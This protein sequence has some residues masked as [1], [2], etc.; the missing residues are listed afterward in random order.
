MRKRGLRLLFALAGA[1]VGASVS[2]QDSCRPVWR[3]VT[4]TVA[5]ATYEMAAEPRRGYFISYDDKFPSTTNEQGWLEQTGCASFSVAV[6]DLGG[7]QV[8]DTKGLFDRMQAN[9]MRG[10]SNNKLLWS[11]SRQVDGYPAREYLTSRNTDFFGNLVFYRTLAVARGS[12]I[13]QFNSHWEGGDTSPIADRAFRSVRVQSAPANP[14]LRTYALLSEAI[15]KYWMFPAKG[16]DYSDYFTPTLLA[17]IE[18][19]RERDAAAI[20]AFGYPRT[21][22]YRSSGANGKVVRVKHDDATVDWTVLDNGTVFTGIWYRKVDPNAAS[23]APAPAPR[24]AAAAIDYAPIKAARERFVSALVTTPAQNTRFTVYAGNDW[25]RVSYAL[26]PAGKTP[27]Q[28]EGDAF[29][30]DWRSAKSVDFVAGEPGAS[31]WWTN[32][33]KVHS[34][35][36]GYWPLHPGTNQI[37]PMLAAG[38]EMMRLCKNVPK[39]AQ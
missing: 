32:Y 14:H 9:S 19:T 33:I 10:G 28:V 31:A 17:Q 29:S 2:A 22:T 35:T 36:G 5:G 13:V 3:T 25:C 38:N 8:A 21:F 23:A 20:K 24:P 16:Y 18:K 34:N 37:G 39:P 26:L 11:R 4:D 12:Q 27:E 7:H 6:W 30:I 1:M 15:T